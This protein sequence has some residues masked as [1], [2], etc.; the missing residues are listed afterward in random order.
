MRALIVLAVALALGACAAPTTSNY[1]NPAGDAV[2]ILVADNRGG[3]AGSVITTVEMVPYENGEP[4]ARR[5]ALVGWYDHQSPR[6][7]YWIDARTVNVCGLSGSAGYEQLIT[8]EIEGTAQQFNVT[9]DCAP[10]VSA[11]RTMTPGAG[12]RRH[13]QRADVGR[14]TAPMRA[15]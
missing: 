3:A 13:L 15:Q 9:A 5:A 4:V 1:V 7:P 6:E 11:L 8:L 12:E 14:R 2:L 10:P